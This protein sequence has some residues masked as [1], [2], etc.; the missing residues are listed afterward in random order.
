MKKTNANDSAEEIIKRAMNALN[1]DTQAE[2]GAILGVTQ[3]AIADAKRK[4]RVPHEWVV[5]L[6]VQKRISPNW[7]LNGFGPKDIVLGHTNKDDT[8]GQMSFLIQSISRISELVEIRGSSELQNKPISYIILW[9]KEHPQFFHTDLNTDRPQDQAVVDF[10]RN[11]CLAVGVLVKYIV[12]DKKYFPYAFEEESQIELIDGLQAAE[13]NSVDVLPELEEYTKTTGNI[14]RV[15]EALTPD[16][17]FSMSQ[18]LTMASKILESKTIYTSALVSSI[19]ALHKAV[20]D[21]ELGHDR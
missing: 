1:V 19:K 9:K 15:V 14:V 13:D 17:D 7:L 2:L 10:I 4:D 18:M 3:G 20:S 16:F 8:F 12:A 5:K 6:A 21:D 11:S